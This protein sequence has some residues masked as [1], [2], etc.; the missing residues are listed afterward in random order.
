MRLYKKF[1]SKRKRR[2][3]CQTWKWKRNAHTLPAIPEAGIAVS[4]A[5][6]K[7]KAR[8]DIVAVEIISHARPIKT[9]RAIQINLY[10]LDI[11]ASLYKKAGIQHQAYQPLPL[12]LH[13]VRTACAYEVPKQS[14]KRMMS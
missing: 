10:N 6:R 1:F 4:A 12:G 7:A 11:T 2:E 5:A 13:A 8:K 14:V 3:Q 9:D